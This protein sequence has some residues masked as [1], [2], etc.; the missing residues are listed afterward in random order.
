MD[1]KDVLVVR[2]VLNDAE[3]AKNKKAPLGTDVTIANYSKEDI[4]VYDAIDDLNDLSKKDKDTLISVGV[5]SDE[6][7]RSGS[8]VQFDQSNIFSNS[9]NFIF[10]S[11]CI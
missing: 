1:L 6:K 9:L 7:E 11:S 5:D 4:S 3:K 2:N 10:L 8:F